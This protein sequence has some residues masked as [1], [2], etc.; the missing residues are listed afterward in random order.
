MFRGRGHTTLFGSVADYEGH[1]NYIMFR[2]CALGLNRQRSTVY[3]ILLL[4]GKHVATQLIFPVHYQTVLLSLLLLLWSLSDLVSVKSVV[5]HTLP[6]FC[7]QTCLTKSKVKLNK[8]KTLWAMFYRN[9]ILGG[10]KVRWFWLKKS[11]QIRQLIFR[12]LILIIRQFP[13]ARSKTTDTEK[14]YFLSR[15]IV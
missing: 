11:K 7:S 13:H 4:K 3:S 1:T 5:W 14:I 2:A 8:I 10:V 15:H 9:T 12:H 6:A